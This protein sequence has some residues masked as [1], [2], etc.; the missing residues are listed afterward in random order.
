MRSKREVRRGGSSTADSGLN[1]D[2]HQAYP[3]SINVVSPPL[4]ITWAIALSPPMADP[5]PSPPEEHLPG[6]N[7]WDTKYISKVLTIIPLYTLMSILSRLKVLIMAMQVIMYSQPPSP[8]ACLTMTRVCRVLDFS[9]E[10]INEFLEMANVDK[11]AVVDSD[12]IVRTLTGS[13]KTAWDSGE[14]MFPSNYLL[15]SMPFYIKW[16]DQIGFQQHML[17]VYCETMHFSCFP[18]S[19]D[20][21]LMLGHMDDLLHSGSSQVPSGQSSVSFFLQHEFQVTRSQIVYFESQIVQLQFK[22]KE[23]LRILSRPTSFTNCSVGASNAFSDSDISL[24]VIFFQKGGVK[25]SF[26]C[27]RGKGYYQYIGN[28]TIIAFATL[29]LFSAVGCMYLLKKWGKQL[30]QTI[31]HL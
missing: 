2:E 8:N 18:W 20:L 1:F 24:A 6:S 10:K 15:S 28:S 5:P 29:G 12:L 30:H 4:A 31:P 16:V 11:E 9:A 21:H 23:I 3:V 13:K 25:F 26:P 14:T 7:S 17:V 27:N 22:E 19:L